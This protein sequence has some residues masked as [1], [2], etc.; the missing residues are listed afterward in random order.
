MTN[1]DSEA[2]THTLRVVSFRVSRN[3]PDFHVAR[4]QCENS[5]KLRNA[6]VAVS[7]EANTYRMWSEDSKHQANTRIS[8]VIGGPASEF[9]NNPYLTGTHSYAAL[10]KHVLKT[11][12][13]SLPAKVAQRTGVLVARSW[14]SF[15]ANR[16]KDGR[17]P[18]FT[19]SYAVCE[20]TIQALSTRALRSNIVLPTGWNTGFQLPR[21]IAPQDVQAARLVPRNDVEFTLEVVYTIPAAVI[22]KPTGELTA[23]IDLGVANLATVAFSDHR[24]GL[25]VAGGPLKSV[26][27]FYNK[28]VAKKQDS[29]D[30][31]WSNYNKYVNGDR[32]KEDPDYVRLNKFT[33]SHVSKWW[34]R[35]NRKITHYIHT[36]TSQLS[37][38]LVRAG[39][40]LVVIGWSP[41]FKHEIRMGRKNNQKF[42]QIPHRKFVDELTFKLAQHGIRVTETEEAYTSQASFLDGDPVPEFREDKRGTHSFSGRR[43][44]RGM[45]RSAKGYLINADLNGGYNMIRKVQEIPPPRGEW[46]KGSVVVPAR[47]LKPKGFQPRRTVSAV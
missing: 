18:R 40:S 25:I 41:G 34:N 2:P 21:F 39:V 37:A 7:R 19:K 38:E 45:Y 6:L 33:S 36:V 24:S 13:I 14:K 15:F 20:Y 16:S 8:D 28:L 5:R 17:A 26:N 23:G 11:N 9:M 10:V 46:D 1:A 30:D 12:D 32:K 31:E 3:H 22:P 27:S 29:L 4:S 42:A 35:R 43:I 44:K 47:R